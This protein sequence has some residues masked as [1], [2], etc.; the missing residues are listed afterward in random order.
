[1]KSVWGRL[2]RWLFPVIVLGLVIFVA[3]CNVIWSTIDLRPPHWD[4]GRHLW[5]SLFY[6]NAFKQGHY[7]NLLTEYRYYPPFVYWVTV[8][9]YL[10]IGLS[11]RV[12]ILSNIVFIGIL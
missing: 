5:T 3:L 4:M 9:F 10:L 11:D 6:L 8:P 12:A 2:P 7:F 1:M